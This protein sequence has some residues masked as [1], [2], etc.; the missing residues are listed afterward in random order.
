MLWR[1]RREFAQSRGA[2]SELLGSFVI[3]AARETARLAS[4]ITVVG[5][6]VYAEPNADI[7]RQLD[8]AKDNESEALS[9]LTRQRFS[10]VTLGMQTRQP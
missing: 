1:R 6:L 4:L 3:V 10:P 2:E 8:V 5:R 7:A 9:S